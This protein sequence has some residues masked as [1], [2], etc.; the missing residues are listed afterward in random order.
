MT[1][2]TDEDGTPMNDPIWP[3]ESAPE[4]QLNIGN[5]GRNSDRR[6]LRAFVMHVLALGLPIVEGEIVAHFYALLMGRSGLAE[7]YNLSDRV[8]DVLF[9]HGFNTPLIIV[10]SPWLVAA[11]LFW[12]RSSSLA[13]LL[14][15][16]TLLGIVWCNIRTAMLGLP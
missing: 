3:P 2:D 5:C 1:V 4:D 6:L 8:G 9:S 10:M 12:H 7:G 13:I 14:V 16:G 11:A 15:A